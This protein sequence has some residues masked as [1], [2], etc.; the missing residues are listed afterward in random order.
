MTG[1]RGV[2][3]SQQQQEKHTNSATETVTNEDRSRMTDR[4]GHIGD[5]HTSTTFEMLRAIAT[6]HRMEDS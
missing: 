6:L 5:Y 2:T 4:S 1:R 3:D